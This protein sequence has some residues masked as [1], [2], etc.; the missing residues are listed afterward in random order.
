MYESKRF[1][2]A[3]QRLRKGT[4]H[5]V[6]QQALPSPIIEFFGA[7]SVVGLLTLARMQVKTAAM[8]PGRFSAFVLALVM[9]Y[10]PIKRLTG[11]HNIF[12]GGI[13]AAQRVFGYLDRHEGVMDKANAVR[14]TRFEKQIRFENVRFH[15][16]KADRTVLDGI[17]LE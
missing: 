2:V 7:A 10:E 9:L 16:P 11:I 14:L 13:G 5:Y 15:Y 17:S 4:L 8:T 1:R 3:S 6:A 12:Q